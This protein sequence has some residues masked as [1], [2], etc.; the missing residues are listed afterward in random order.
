MSVASLLYRL[1][2]DAITYV[3][4]LL[5]PSAGWR[6]ID[7]Y[8]IDGSDFQNWLFKHRSAV[9]NQ[10][11]RK[12]RK[13]KNDRR[14]YQND[15]RHKCG[16]LV[17]YV[18]HRLDDPND[19]PDNAGRDSAEMLAHAAGKVAQAGYRIVNLDCVVA[20]E[21]PQLAPQKLAL[22]TRIAEILGIGVADVG[23]KA[24]TGE[25]LGSV[26]RG[27]AIEARCVALLVRSST[28]A[29]VNP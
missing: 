11:P 13:T 14:A 5:R 2:F 28:D 8:L 24:K 20:A 4:L 10:M 27:E 21:A 3:W 19:D 6:P 29:P 16:R 17:L 23:L 18:C 12:P 7:L 26:G 22:Q 1:L 15:L 25:K 9:L